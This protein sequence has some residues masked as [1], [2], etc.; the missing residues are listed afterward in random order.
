MLGIRSVWSC[1]PPTILN[2]I[3]PSCKIMIP[4]LIN[5]SGIGK[6]FDI[7]STALT[8][9]GEIDLT[10]KTGEFVAIMGPSGSGKSTLLHILGCLDRPSSGR[11]YFSGQDV[12]HASDRQL[13]RIRSET[14]GFVFQTFNLIPSLNVY[15]NVELPFLYQSMQAKRVKQKVTEAIDLVGLKPRVMHKP[16]ELSG[17]EMQRVAI[18]RAISI[19]PKLILADEP[20][21]NLD[22][23]TGNDIMELF[24]DLHNLGATVVMVTHNQ[25]VA[26]FAQR[27]IQLVDGRIL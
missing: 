1:Q 24:K 15:E 9:L 11:Y 5:A 20:T 26:D 2:R 22:T 23:E 13:S 14:I 17:G 27:T 12:L 21:G 6:K 19:Q 25:T 4:F 7:G 16:S 8:V 3:N 18:A 10:V